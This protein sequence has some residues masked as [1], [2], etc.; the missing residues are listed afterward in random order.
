MSLEVALIGPTAIGRSAAAD[1]RTH[2]T[3]AGAHGATAHS[4]EINRTS[5][6]S[7]HVRGLGSIPSAVHRVPHLGFVGEDHPAENT[8]GA[9]GQVPR[10]GHLCIMPVNKGND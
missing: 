9:V 2:R 7:R 3:A 4:N 8:R 6:V 1:F 10:V 5:A